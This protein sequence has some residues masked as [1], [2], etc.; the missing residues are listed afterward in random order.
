MGLWDKLRGELVDIVE[1]LDPGTDTMVHRFE[2]YNNEIKYDA[3]LV[4]REGQAAVFVNEGQLADVFTPGSY[5]LVTANLPVLTTL[6]GWKYGF[7]SPFKAEVYFVTTRRFTDLKWGTKN[8]IMLRDAEF[9]PVRLRAF[10]TYEVRVSDPAAMIREI[11]GTKGQFTTDDITA[12]LRNMIVSRFTDILGESHIP[13]LSLAANYDELGQFITQRIGPEFAAYGIELTRLLVE[14]I[15]LPP[16]VEK[17]LDQRTAMGVIGNLQQ[18]T[19]Y[20][21]AEAIREAARNEGG[22][23]GAGVGLG[24]GFA[25]AGQ[26]AQT[27]GAA[28]QPGRTAPPPLPGQA[29]EFYAAVDNKQAGPFDRDMFQQKVLA[30]E[31]TRETLVW[32]QGMADWAPAGQ[33][34]ELQD[35]FATVPPPIPPKP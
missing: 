26:M 20:Q 3:K 12:Q 4:V 13:A 30:G 22:T 2:R 25:M 17:V 33:V 5:A 6:Q 28:S 16:E 31:L 1:W 9:G 19:Q 35:L 10:G 15:S 29:A 34:A 32:R 8:P 7:E 18:Y 14:N 24:M 23:A 27:L 21:A 11:V